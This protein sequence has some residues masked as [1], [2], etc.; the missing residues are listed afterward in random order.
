V[1]EDG[2]KKFGVGLQHELQAV[3]ALPFGR[4]MELTAARGLDELRM[5]SW[6]TGTTT[7]PDLGEPVLRLRTRNHEIALVERD[8]T[9]A[10]VSLVGAHVHAVAAGRDGVAVEGTLE[11]LHELFPPPDPSSAHEV[12]VTFWTYS[13]HGPQPSWRS[14]G[15]PGWDEIEANYSEPTRT[16]AS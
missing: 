9:L 8:G 7:I 14:I 1:A 15:V 5:D 6:P 2:A 16:G 3:E 12:P 10:H 4:F 11:A 13:P